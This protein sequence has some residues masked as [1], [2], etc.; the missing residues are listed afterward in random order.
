MFSSVH[1][2]RCHV[3]CHLIHLST[4]SEKLQWENNSSEV[5]RLEKILLPNRPMKINEC[6]GNYMTKSKCLEKEKKKR[7]ESSVIIS[8]LCSFF[9]KMSAGSLFNIWKH[10]N[11]DW[12]FR[13]D[14]DAVLRKSQKIN[15]YFK[16]NL[17]AGFL[18]RLRT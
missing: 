3:Y 9:H 7:I 14:Q 15:L 1:F 12:L 2:E 8:I 16:K 10:R 5:W 6:Q 18:W 13:I 11:G 17:L 4:T